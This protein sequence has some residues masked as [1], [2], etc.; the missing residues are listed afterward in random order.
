MIIERNIRFGDTLSP[1]WKWLAFYLLLCVGV[2][3]AELELGWKVGLPTVEI[4]LIGTALSILMGFRVDAAY[5]RWWEARKIWGEVVN[6]SRS[7]AREAI[8]FLQVQEE[9]NGGAEKLVYRQ[10]AFVHAMR[11]HLRKQT[12]HYDE[13]KPFLSE[14]E[15]AKALGKV[16]VPNELLLLHL[17]QLR[18]YHQK[19]LLSDYLFAKIEEVIVVLTDQMGK[20]E[21]IKNTPF[22]VPYSYFSYLS[23]HIFACLVPFGLVKELG[24]ITIPIAMIVIFIFVIIEL[25]ALEIQDPFE[26]RDNDTP[27]T[28][29]SRNIEIDLKDMLDE[30]SLPEKEKPVDG[31]MM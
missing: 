23:V 20:A 29:I 4:T 15:A 27:M 18:G 5:Q 24:Y 26:G 8:G 13:I 9:T 3:V 19:G 30:R 14:D 2:C 25:I 7:F 1:L 21:R 12:E 10:I 17:K 16:T 28:T 11:L 6:S 22:P 31:V